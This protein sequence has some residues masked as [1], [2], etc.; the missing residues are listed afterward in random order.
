MGQKSTASLIIKLKGTH[1][2]D[3]S[4]ARWNTDPADYPDYAVAPLNPKVPAKRRT[5]D[6]LVPVQSAGPFRFEGET[7]SDRV[8]EIVAPAAIERALAIY[9]QL[10]PRDPSVLLQARKI[11]TQHIYG[12]VDR[13]E[14][15][16]QRLTVGGLVHLK[17]VER[18]H[19]IKSAQD[20][21]TKKR[22]KAKASA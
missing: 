3:S 8:E 1:H 5:H 19:S 4:L 11:L 14:H 17:A 10:Q 18:D 9:Q 20:V 15:N 2:A 21:P 13:G 6:A 7:M 16:E 22:K 12:M